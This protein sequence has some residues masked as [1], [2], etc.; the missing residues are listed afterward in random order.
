MKRYKDECILLNHHSFGESDLIVS[1][2]TRE[3]GK[4]SCIAKGGRCSKKRFA[5]LERGALLYILYREK[6]ENSLGFLEESRSLECLPEWRKSYLTISVVGYCLELMQNI[7][8]EHHLAA[9]KYELFKR[10]LSLLDRNQIKE[11]LIVFQKELLTYSGWKAD[12]KACGICG[13]R[14]K[15]ATQIDQKIL[16]HYWEHILNKPLKS[17]PLLEEAFLV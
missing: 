9:E 5:S 6:A 15:H 14:W 4:R 7:L 13:Y 17:R 2:F 3:R 11:K 10:F 1:L 8:P 16:D 12:F